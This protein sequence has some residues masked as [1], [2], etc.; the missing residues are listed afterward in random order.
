[1]QERNVSAALIVSMLLAAES[2]IDAHM[3]TVPRARTFLHDVLQE[4]CTS[5][6]RQDSGQHQHLPAALPSHTSWGT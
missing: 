4:S 3:N 5:V 2:H 6:T 1:M